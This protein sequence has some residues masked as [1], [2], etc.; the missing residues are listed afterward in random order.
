MF[1]PVFYLKDLL[2]ELSAVTNSNH[3]TLNFTA[4]YYNKLTYMCNL[5]SFPTALYQINMQAHWNS[6]KLL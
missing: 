3:K 5:F 1:E 2:T 4:G 6:L